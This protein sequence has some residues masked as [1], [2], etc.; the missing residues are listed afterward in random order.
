MQVERLVDTVKP[1]EAEERLRAL[2]AMMGDEE[3]RQWEADI[4]LTIGRF[5]P[6]RLKVLTLVL[7]RRLSTGNEA[8]TEAQPVVRRRRRR[9]MVLTRAELRSSRS[10]RSPS[11]QVIACR[12]DGEW[13]GE[14]GVVRRVGVGGAGARERPP[15]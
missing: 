13:T 4:R 9:R 14:G 1:Q 5:L 6:K 7:D 8:A 3:L 10:P 11:I 2:I 15:G 12:A